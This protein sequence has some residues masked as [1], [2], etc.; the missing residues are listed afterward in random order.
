MLAVLSNEIDED[1]INT[2]KD[3]G[4][5]IIEKCGG[6]PLAVKVMGGLLCQT[7]MLRRDWEQ[8]VDDSKWSITEMPQE[9]NHAVYLSYEAMPPYLR[10]C[11]LYYS[12]LPKSKTFYVPDVIAMWI[13]EGF[14][15]GNSND[16]EETGKKYYKELISRNLIEPDKGVIDQWSCSMHDVVRSFAQYMSRDEALIDHNGEIGILTKLNSQKFLCLSMETTILQSGELEWKSLQEQ[17]SVRTLISIGRIKMNPGDSLLNFSSLRTLYIESEDVSVLVESLHQLKHLRYLALLNAEISVLPENIGKMKLLQFIDLRECSKL[18]NLPDSIVKLGQLRHLEFPGKV[19]MIPRE[20]RCLTN[21]RNLY[22]FPAYVDGD[23]C[24]LDEL[25]PLSQ[26]RYLSLVQLENISSSSSAANAR[27]GEKMH[28][29]DLILSC[30]SKLG[31]DGLV[32][33]ENGVCQEEKTRIEKVFGELCPPTSVQYLD[34]SGYFGQQLPNWMTSKS[35]VPLNNLKSLLFS[36]LACCTQLPNGLCQLPCLQFLQ[37]AR[38]PCIRS[39]GT[40]FLHPSQG[41]SAPF[42]R[43]QRM[44][45]FG[46]VEWEEWVWEGKVQ[47]M[48]RLEELLVEKCKLRRVPPGLA[49]NARALRKLSIQ[50][51]KQISCLQKFP[52]VVELTVDWCPDLERI[53]DLPKVQKLT[54]TGCW[55]VKVVK[56]LPALQRLVL[57]DGRMETVP[58]YLGDVNPSYLELRCGLTLLTSIAAG[59]SGPEFAKFS[60]VERVKAR[61]AYRNSDFY[62]LY[63]RGPCSF[64]TNVNPSFLSRG[65]LP[66]FEDAQRLESALKMPRRAFDYVCNLLKEKSWQDANKYTFPDGRYLCL[67]D[68]V[69]VALIVLNSGET[70]ATVGSSVALNESIVSQVTKSFVVAMDTP[71]WPGTTEMEKIK[72]KFDKIRGLPNCCGVVHAARIPFGSQNSDREKKNEDMLMQVTIDSDMRFIDVHL[73]S[74]DNMKKSSISHDSS[75][76]EECEKGTR[77]NGS[78]LN[79][80][81]GRQ[82]GEY[83]I[84]DAGYPL[85]PWLLTP[86]HPENDLSDYQV[87]FNRRHSEAMAVVTRS[88]LE[89]LKD[90]WKFLHGGRWRPE[91]RFELHQAIQA[92]C[93]L[94]NIVLEMEC[95]V[96]TTSYGAGSKEVRQLADEDAAMARDIL[97]QHLTSKPLESGG[98]LTQLLLHLNSLNL[99]ISFLCRPN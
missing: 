21:M 48:P 47:A 33:E 75:L 22:G 99:S 14:I 85:L 38:A 70:P 10:Q 3:I 57:E 2:L 81:D 39:V 32:K 19:S 24:S 69:A 51:V 94:H 72:Y 28:M 55:K 93:K 34:I 50:N 87:E 27:L 8:V 96:A 49:S 74:P 91:H 80:S 29:I 90:T 54:I 31:D 16:L 30:T 66:I 17:K 65:T 73:G 76:F 20:F 59:E 12:I 11:F 4:L 61:G 42:P 41:A 98:K 7:E 92:C 77:L 13:S 67:E 1:H 5:K 45:L 9:L 35:M 71:G 52:S 43:L 44:Q 62:V 64:D 82:V 60:H 25:G 56:Y 36:D 86:Y 79:L 95:K 18:V 83:V 40:E 89:R 58:G 15:H 78:K 97:S 63:T 26:L 68:G 53:T 23:W 84:G 88:A 6:L 46:M 37:V